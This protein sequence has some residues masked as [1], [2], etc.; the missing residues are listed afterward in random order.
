MNPKAALV[1][2][3]NVVAT[4]PRNYVGDNGAR[5]TQVL[6][7]AHYNMACCYSALGQVDEGLR[8]LEAALVVGFENYARVGLGLG[9]A[10]LSLGDLVMLLGGVGCCGAVEQ[11]VCSELLAA[12]QRSGSQPTHRPPTHPPTHPPTQPT[13]TKRSPQA[14]SDKNLAALRES[15]KFAA[16]MDRYDEPVINWSAV[17]GTLNVFGN[18]FSKK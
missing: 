1:D 6:P 10:L 14:R 2:F 4:E 11:V 16:L 12:C 8:S 17:Q 18:L 5:V 13:K 7:V 9:G 3:E 15:P